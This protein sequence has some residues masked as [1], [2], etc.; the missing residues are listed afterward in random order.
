VINIVMGLT[1]IR[2]RTFWWVSQLGM[3]PGTC[4]FILAGA[5]APSLK[6]IADE[7]IASILDWKLIAALM[8]LGALPLAIK[9]MVSRYRS[10]KVT[11]SGT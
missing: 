7:G 10:R 4:V 1:T 6:T 11:A 2:T 3:L 5:T 9:W 8:L